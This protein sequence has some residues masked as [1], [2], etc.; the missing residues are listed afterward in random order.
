MLFFSLLK[1]G[2]PSER[3]LISSNALRVACEQHSV[4]QIVI[5]LA[6]FERHYDLNSHGFLEQLYCA[7]DLQNG[8]YHVVMMFNSSLLRRGI[9]AAAADFDG[10]PS[11]RY[12][13]S[14]PS[15]LGGCAV[16]A[17][18]DAVFSMRWTIGRCFPLQPVPKPSDPAVAQV[19]QAVASQLMRD[20]WSV[21]AVSSGFAI[22]DCK[23]ALDQPD[24]IRVFVRTKGLLPVFPPSR[25]VP[26]EIKHN[27]H[28]YRIDVLEG[29]YTPHVN[30][31]RAD[32]AIAYLGASV[33]CIFAADNNLLRHSADG[34]LASCKTGTIGAYLRDRNGAVYALTNKHAVFP[35][36]EQRNEVHLQS[37]CP[38]SIYLELQAVGVL[39]QKAER[40]A[41]AAAQARGKPSELEG[42]L[43]AE[44][45]RLQIEADRLEKFA[46][47]VRLGPGT[48]V[49]FRV[50][51]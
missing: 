12:C 29:H 40:R 31:C 28:L 11:I 44:I 8:D 37:P 35:D 49:C 46:D 17:F 50:W 5:L 27:G 22:T 13:A 48:N 19:A 32:E 4:T 2:L 41:K 45:A 14:V 1:H 30:A 39:L 20:N 36:N 51:V 33:S 38:K 34:V 15:S 7:K 9:P 21:T 3:Q 10:I 43:Q 47:Y 24:V 42:Q 25:E 6:W 16:Q 26:R 18:D 23:P